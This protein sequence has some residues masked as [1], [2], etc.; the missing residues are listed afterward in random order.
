MK[1][2]LIPVLVMAGYWI[3]VEVFKSV[4]MDLSLDWK[5]WVVFTGGFISSAW[6]AMAVRS[7]AKDAFEREIRSLKDELEDLRNRV[8]E[9]EE[10]DEFEPGDEAY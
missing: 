6:F 9:V 3:A 2:I 4:W 8:E 5:F 7:D 1:D 10:R